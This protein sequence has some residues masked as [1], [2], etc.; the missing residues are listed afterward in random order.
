MKNAS[1]IALA[2]AL[3]TGLS[4]TSLIAADPAS[5]RGWGDDHGHKG[6][7]G[8]HK[9]GMR[10]GMKGPM[11]MFREFDTNGDRALTKDELDTGLTKKIKD[12]DTNGD[13]AVDLEEFKAEWMR[14]TQ[15]R[16]VRAFQRMDRDGSGTVTL[17]EISEPASFMF[18]R[19]DRNDDG[20]IDKSDRRE[21][22]W[23][24]FMQK[25]PAPK[26]APKS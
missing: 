23:G 10:G 13:G 6:H 17:E 16:M 24:R 15:Q 2:F 1:K 12:N 18:E 21:R 14:M 5:A 25:Q 19:M 9:K 22:K 8:W 11:K 4:A 26:Q 20:K 3:M 7:H